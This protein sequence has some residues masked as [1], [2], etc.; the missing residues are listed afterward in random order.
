[1]VAKPPTES[2]PTSRPSSPAVIKERVTSE[3]PFPTEAEA[4]ENALLQAQKRV[5]QALGQ[6]DP[7]VRYEPSLAVV[8]NEFVRKD[9]R[10][11]R[12]PTPAEQE[13]LKSSGYHSD[14][15]YVE[16]EVEVTADQVRELRTQD[17]VSGALRIL[18]GLA[19]VA[20]AGFLFLE[21]D[22]WTKGYLTS[23]LAFVAIALAGSVAAALVLV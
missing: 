13:L 7:P 10:A 4:E 20:L 5:T 15:V 12:R 23:W 17:R 22:E 18:G 1:V 16:Y 11:V 8:K 3:I 19:A 14:R 2:K 21:V 6:L 9:S